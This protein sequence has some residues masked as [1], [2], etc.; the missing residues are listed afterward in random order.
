MIL[1]G[2]ELPVDRAFDHFV[3][4]SLTSIRIVDDHSRTTFSILGDVRKHLQ[5]RY[6][7]LLNAVW[8]DT[9]SHMKVGFRLNFR[10]QP[11]V[12]W[13]WRAFQENLGWW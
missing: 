4:A 1:I 2:F 10:K 5:I 11:L 7:A 13:L 6:P 9:Y 3:E 8:R 12:V